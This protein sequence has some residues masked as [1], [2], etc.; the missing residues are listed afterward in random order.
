MVEEGGE[1]N[2]VNNL[3]E[4]KDEKKQNPHKFGKNQESVTVRR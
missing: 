3:K 2:T 1:S 4:E